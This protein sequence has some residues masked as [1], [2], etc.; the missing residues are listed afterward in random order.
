[1]INNHLD[2]VLKTLK[3]LEPIY[4]AACPEAT[5]DDFERIVSPD[6]WE[7][8][9]SGKVY[10]REFALG[11]LKSRQASPPK[12]MWQTSDYQV[13]R[14]SKT[15]YLLTYTLTQ[16]MRVTKRLTV[17][18]YTAKGWQAVYHQGTVVSS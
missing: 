4:H 12:E 10:T 6:F 8:G 5:E 3:Q 17:W 2:S 13:K 9:A 1:M 14:V 11:V 18:Q 7:I 16:P 15:I